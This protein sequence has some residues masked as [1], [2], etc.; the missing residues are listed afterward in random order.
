MA[1]IE[2][3]NLSKIINID[4]YDIERS[5]SKKISQGKLINCGEIVT[6]EDDEIEDG[7]SPIN[8]VNFIIDSEGSDVDIL[9]LNFKK[10][11]LMHSD[12]TV[13]IEER[14]RPTNIVT[15]DSDESEDESPVKKV[16]M[17]KKQVQP[18]SVNV[19]PPARPASIYLGHPP[20]L[21]SRS[22]VPYSVDGWT[23]LGYQGRLPPYS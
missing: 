22:V 10:A 21:A 3:K 17:P 2:T 20:P 13:K 4:D 1:K 6:I 15:I 11:V 18:P 8:P 12:K 23:T 14:Y 16:L 19:D 7:P 5:H 9:A